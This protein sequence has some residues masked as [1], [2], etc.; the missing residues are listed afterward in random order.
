M[1]DTSLTALPSS[2]AAGESVTYLRA[3]LPG[4]G[5]ADGWALALS[6]AGEKTLT[7]S[8]TT[9]GEA[10]RVTLTAA[11]T[12][13]LE[14]GSYRWVE[15]LTKGTDAH[16]YATGEV[17]VTPNIAAAEAGELQ[18]W[19]EKTLPILEAAI[20]GRLPSGMENYQIG[21]RAVG[22]MG[23]SEL[24][25]RRAEVLSEVNRIR[26]AGKFTTYKVTFPEV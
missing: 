26:N 14:A 20:A 11:A 12:T 21:N 1:I 23:I 16:D 4:Y 5:P 15:R 24:W 3:A 25:A 8:A 18:T 13:T 7:V 22:K 6:I 2:F 17:I 19:A 10:F 9:E